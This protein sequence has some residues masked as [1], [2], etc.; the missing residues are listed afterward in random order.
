M[1]LDQ[2]L[3]EKVA[4][5]LRVARA[6]LLPGGITGV[7]VDPASKSQA[8]DSILAR[9]AE[10]YAVRPADEKTPPTG[11]DPAAAALFEALVE[12]AFLVANADGEFDSEERAAFEEVVLAATKQHVSKEQ[13]DALLSDFAELL[14]EDGQ[15]KRIAAVSKTVT[16]PEQQGEVLRVAAFIAHISGGCSDVERQAME[17]LAVGFG[18]PA[19][20]VDDALSVASTILADL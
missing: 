4:N 10:L 15:E 5:S 14:A 17:K 3:L 6:S 20:A 13:L 19:G 2:S 8:K 16:R 9:A 1:P 7:V 11:F 18:L 12:G